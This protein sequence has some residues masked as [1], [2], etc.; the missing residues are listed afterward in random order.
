ME[1]E[2]QIHR[3]IEDDMQGTENNSYE[4][5]ILY[6]PGEAGNGKQCEQKTMV[7]GQTHVAKQ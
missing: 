1:S 4:K 2:N 5:S 6:D 3:V 7:S